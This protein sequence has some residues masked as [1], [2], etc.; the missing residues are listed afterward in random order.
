MYNV[1]HIFLIQFQSTLRLY[2]ATGRPENF[3]RWI[4]EFQSTL[5]LYG[6]TVHQPVSLPCPGVSIHAPPIRSD[7]R[8]IQYLCFLWCFNPRSAYTERPTSSYRFTI[9]ISVSIHAPPIRSDSS[10]FSHS[11][12]IIC[13]NPRSAYTERLIDNSF[14]ITFAMVSIHAPPIRSDSKIYQISPLKFPSP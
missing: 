3:I 5:R 2:G 9:L 7:L 10:F 1:L 12:L 4:L 6:A 13:F 14:S 8:Q 11:T